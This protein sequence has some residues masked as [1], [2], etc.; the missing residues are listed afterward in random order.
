MSRIS[1]IPS[2]AHLHE[3]RRGPRTRWGP[4]SRIA[5]LANRP[6]AITGPLTDEQ[7]DAYVLCLRIDEIQHQLQQE[8]EEVALSSRPR[9]LS[10][11]PEYDAAGRRTNT[12]EQRRRSRLEREH[13]GL[14]E[15]ALETVPGYRPPRSYRHWH[16]RNSTI[17]REKIYIPVADHPSV[18]FIGQIPGPRGST[19]RP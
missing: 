9:S 8:A 16:S 12:R 11:P 2:I 14:E 3:P 5:S 17:L 4:Y 13:R 18:N 10:P 15:T 7:K 1:S 6:L 19:S